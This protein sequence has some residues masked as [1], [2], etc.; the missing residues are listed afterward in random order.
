LDII[1]LYA[2]FILA[3]PGPNTK[4]AFLLLSGVISLFL[5]NI[6]RISGL[7]VADFYFSNHWHDIHFYSSYL[8]FYPVILSLWY[9]WTTISQQ[10]YFFSGNELPSV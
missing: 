6:F 8:L 4:R 9:Y 2:G 3:Y 10:Q 5:L 7:I 1:G